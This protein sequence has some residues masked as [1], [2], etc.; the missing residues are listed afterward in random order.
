MQRRT[1]TGFRKITV[2]AHRPIKRSTLAKLLKAAEIP[3][4]DF[5]TLLG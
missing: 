4:E 2:V 3:V 5:L 1:E